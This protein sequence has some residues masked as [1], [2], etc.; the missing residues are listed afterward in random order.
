MRNALI[1]A[2]VA[3][4]ALIA[5]QQP[6]APPAPP[7]FRVEETTIAQIHEA[8]TSGRLTCKALVDMYLRRIYAYDKNGPGINAMVVMNADGTAPRTLTGHNYDTYSSPSWSADGKWILIRG[9][10]QLELVRASD[11]EVIG[12]PTLK[13]SQTSFKP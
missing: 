12:L 4:A 1:L 6:A 8:M 3:S 13:L 9:L 10:F 2:V 11:F 5:Q 7:P